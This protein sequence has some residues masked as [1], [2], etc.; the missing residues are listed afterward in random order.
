MKDF[1]YFAYGSLVNR[2]TR[3]QQT[4]AEPARLAGWIRQWRLCLD[5]PRGG[6]CALTAER[7]SGGELEGVLVVDNDNGI[8][9]LDER[10]VGYRRQRVRPQRKA[11]PTVEVEAEIYISNGEYNRWA[12][13]LILFGAVIWTACWRA[14]LIYGGAEAQK[15]F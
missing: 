4:R 3:P 14:T 10:E 6:V 9:A 15:G 8:V 2:R 12:A 13:L 1:V 11:V 5:T 7:R